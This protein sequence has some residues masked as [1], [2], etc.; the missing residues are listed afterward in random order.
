MPT[1]V[2]IVNR[3]LAVIAGR[4]PI[5]SLQEQGTEAKTARIFWDPTRQAM[6]RA[7]PWNFARK[8]ALLTLIKAAP[9]TP[10]N[11]TS[12]TTWSSAYPAPPWLYS[13]AIPPDC[14]FVRYISP[15]IDAN[16]AGGISNMF[17]VPTAAGLP[18]VAIRPVRFQIASD[19]DTSGNPVGCIL[20]NQSAA[21]AIYTWDVTNPS[22]WDA[23]FQ[24]AM[25]DALATRFAMPLSGK[26]DLAK[27]FAQKAIY[28][29]NEA[30][31]RD[32]NEGITVAESVP[33]WL[34]VRGV[35]GDFTTPVQGPVWSTP[36]FLIL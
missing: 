28:S 26:L 27:T 36:S 7:A 34:R 9:G 14:V 16:V 20:T 15:Q 5:A 23:L 25:V 18:M 32:G 35:G 19:T 6:L 8:T 21:I 31:L 17:S 33:D 30:Q 24:E 10:E 4:N 12:A 29:I 3:A 22:L 11:P 13:Y 2:D 1:A